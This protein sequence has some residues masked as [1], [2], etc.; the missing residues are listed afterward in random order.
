MAIW[1][2]EEVKGRMQYAGKA[3]YKGIALGPVTVLG[4]QEESVEPRRIGDSDR[5]WKRVLEAVEGA[6]EQLQ[7]L[8]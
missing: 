7:E 5:E 1:K 6:R 2:T 4:T 3:V 8:H